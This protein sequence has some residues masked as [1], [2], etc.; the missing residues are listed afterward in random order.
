MLYYFAHSDL[1]KTGGFL[2]S[3]IVLIKALIT[4]SAY[5]ETQAEYDALIADMETRINAVQDGD[6]RD[7]LRKRYLEFLPWSEIMKEISDILNRLS[8][9][10][11]ALSGVETA[12][13]AIVE[14]SE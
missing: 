7:L 1:L 3:G 14:V 11:T 12:L 5:A 4:G 2:Q 10:E 9:V 6:A 13:A 8:V